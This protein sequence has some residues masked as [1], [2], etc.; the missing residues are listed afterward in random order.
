[1][2][3]QLKQSFR[4]DGKDPHWYHFEC[5]F[6]KNRPKSVDDIDGLYALRPEDQKLIESKVGKNLEILLP[7]PSTSKGKGKKRKADSAT[8]E[9][10]KDFRVEYAKSGRSTCAGCGNMIANQEVR[11]IYINYDTEVGALYGGQPFSHHPAC[12][13]EIRDR[14]KYYLGGS[15]LP[16]FKDLDKEDQKALKNAIK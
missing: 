14:Y 7:E 2:K 6:V 11:V 5:F 8:A 13:N 16:G 9:R 10:L 3:F 1:M 15:D 4:H 12:F